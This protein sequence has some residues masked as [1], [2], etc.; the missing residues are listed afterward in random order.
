MASSSSSSSSSSSADIETYEFGPDALDDLIAL[1]PSVSEDWV[2]AVKQATRRVQ[3]QIF[4]DPSVCLD[5]SIATRLGSLSNIVQ[6]IVTTCKSASESIRA[7][8]KAR[9]LG[10]EFRHAVSLSR[11]ANSE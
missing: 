9:D 5:P 1:F 7:A 3:E 2:E 4:N 8:S 10:G 11:L 6:A